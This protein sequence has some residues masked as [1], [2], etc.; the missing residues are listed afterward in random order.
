MAS[1]RA[2]GANRH[3][4]GLGRYLR[5]MSD[6]T[7]RTFDSIPAGAFREAEGTQHWPVLGDG[8]ATFFRT[9]SLATSARLAEAIASIDGIEGHKPAID[10]RDDGVTV[11][12]LTR[13]DD[14]WGMTRQD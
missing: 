11:R 4:C 5:R 14:A 12:L 13:T 7:P 3:A 10:I 9:S 6:T 2:L 1:R 8:A